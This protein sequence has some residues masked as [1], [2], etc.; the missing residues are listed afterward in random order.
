[1]DTDD[2]L[3]VGCALSRDSGRYAARHVVNG[4]KLIA[5]PEK[6]DIGD[7]R[8]VFVIK[9]ERTAPGD[10]TFIYAPGAGAN[11]RDPFGALLAEKLPAAGV[12]LI[13]FQFP[14]SEAGRSAP[15]RPPVLEATWRAVAE[16]VRPQGGR[17]SIGGRSMGGRIASQVVAAGLA[18]DQ[19]TLF[20][21]PLHPPRR[22]EQARTEHL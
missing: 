16:A 22:P 18:V 14:Y 1:M 7:G 3:R 17:L 2:D 21:Y 5:E 13:R 19:L 6:I 12:T 8:S 10:W 4:T 15:D 20:A 11:I 9:S